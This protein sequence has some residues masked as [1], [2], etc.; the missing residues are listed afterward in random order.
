MNALI[1]LSSIG[2]ARN[3][4]SVICG[5]CSKCEAC[6][7]EA[8][9]SFDVDISLMMKRILAFMSKFIPKTATSTAVV[10]IPENNDIQIIEKQRK[11]KAK[12][13]GE[14]TSLNE[15]Q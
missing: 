4:L 1:E 7:S 11:K 2:F 3:L 15:E 14:N 6:K 9:D 5:S 12:K 13:T 8:T 10:R